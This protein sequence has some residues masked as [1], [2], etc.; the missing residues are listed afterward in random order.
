MELKGKQVEAFVEAL[1]ESEKL[2]K[3]RENNDVKSYM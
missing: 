3:V 2:N 1:D